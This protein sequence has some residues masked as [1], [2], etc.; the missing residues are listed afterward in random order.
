MNIIAAGVTTL[1]EARYFAAMGVQ[2]LGFNGSVLSPE[3]IKAIADWVVGPNL[4]VEV[5][6]VQEEQLFE[7]ASKVRLDAIAMPLT[8]DA[9]SW[10]D[11][12]I[13][14]TATFPAE[15][16]TLDTTINTHLLIRCD[17]MIEND[18][19]LEI[20]QRICINNACWIEYDPSV[21]S[22]FALIQKLPAK[23]MILRC[24]GNVASDAQIYAE[25]D[26][27]FERFT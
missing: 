17:D 9:P 11:G 4:F 25:Y 22:P 21:D 1:D 20:L 24:T 23:G 15:Q 18:M 3:Q 13:L 27:F 8:G 6:T 2:W 7:T 14:R 12:L 26:T 19:T 5:S 16:E 10:Y